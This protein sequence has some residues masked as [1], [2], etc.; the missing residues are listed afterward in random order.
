MTIDSADTGLLDRTLGTGDHKTVGRLWIFSGLVLGVAALVI[1]LAVAVEQ[2]DDGG[3][4]FVEDGNEL[5]QLWS[6]SR[7]LLIFG[8]VVAV[9]VGIG[10]FIVPLQVGSGTI[11]FPRG[12]AAAFWVWDVSVLMLIAAYVGNGGP[13]GGRVD[14]V[15]L[16]AMALGAMI[17]SVVWALICIAT[18]VLGARAAGMRLEMVPVT[19][20]SYL[21]F[22][23]LGIVVL[24]IQMGQLI[25]AFIDVRGG[26][27]SL[28]DTTPLSAVMDT[29]S[30]APSIYWLAVPTLGMALET[31]GVH[32]GRP[33][34]FHKSALGLIGA[35]VIISFAAHVTSFGNRGR[36]VDFDNA[37][38][39]AALLVAVLPILGSLALGADSLRNG[40]PKFRVPLLSGLVSGLLLLG[41]ATVALLGIIEPVVGFLADLA[42]RQPDVPERLLLNGTSFNAGVTAFIVTA[43]LVTGHAGVHH[44][45]HKIWGHQFNRAIGIPALLLIAGGGALWAVG[46][47]VAGVGG[48][49]AL[50]TLVESEDNL[51]A[52][53]NV[54]VALGVAAAAGGVAL[55]LLNTVLSGVLGQGSVAEPWKGRTLEW[56]SGSPPA[57][58]NFATQPTVRSHLPLDDGTDAATSEPS[59]A[60]LEEVTA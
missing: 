35:L 8:A 40:T 15:V 41:G 31:I 34:R 60:P 50:P 46:E 32:T 33:I 23:L 5:V 30:L 28:V 55:T 17:G 1:R 24:P 11:A 2:I 27:Q 4:A 36:P 54:A 56:L 3:F 45:G 43:A 57:Y 25:L 19:A 48:Q 9:L 39:V 37:L 29:I 52:A 12:A 18:T 21:V 13:G 53:G 58:A 49:P 42:N 10:T 59:E 7:D 22:A 20:W 14:F 38:L 26:Y 44:W 16:W 47:V 51:V 6:L